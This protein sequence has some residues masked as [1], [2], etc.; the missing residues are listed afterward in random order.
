MDKSS[1]IHKMEAA[2]TALGLSPSTIGERAGQGGRF[3]AK[4]L[5]GSRVW[6]ETIEAVSA[7]IDAMI[8][9]ARK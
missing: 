1:L 6:P 5:G 2:A 4:L 9:E 8:A 3:Y 7:K